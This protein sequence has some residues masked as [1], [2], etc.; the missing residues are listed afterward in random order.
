MMKEGRKEGT[1]EGELK[2]FILNR[3]SPASARVMIDTVT[4][5][6]VL[7][8]RLCWLTCAGTVGGASTVFE[9]AWV[10]QHGIRASTRMYLGRGGESLYQRGLCNSRRRSA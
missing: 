5:P 6:L 3:R 7:A 4:S 2:D 10:S 9:P 8:R 1:E